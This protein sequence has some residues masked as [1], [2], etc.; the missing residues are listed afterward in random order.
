MST[1]VSDHTAL[2]SGRSWWGGD[3]GAA[4]PLFVTYSF[5]T[6]HYDYL[7]GMS[8]FDT[9]RGSFRELTAMQRQQAQA[10]LTMWD[11]ASGIRFV[12]V[13]AGQGDIRFGS[14]DFSSRFD[15]RD[16]AAFAYYPYA[17]GEGLPDGRGAPGDV[18]L[19]REV[20]GYTAEGT[21]H[22][23]L[24][25]IGHTL[26]LKHPFEGD[27]QLDGT[28][29]NTI[30]TVMSYNGDTPRLGTLDIT[31]IQ[32]IYGTNDRDG[33]PGA[34][35]SWDAATFTLTQAG[36]EAGETLRGV[37]TANVV[38]AGGGDDIVVTWSGRDTIDGGAGD[39][40]IEAG[41][42]DDTL[43]G[44][45]GA[46][47]L[48]GSVGN[49]TLDGGDGDDT[50]LGGDDGND[51]ADGG[52]GNDAIFGGVGN[53]RLSGSAGRDVLWGGV[54]DDRLDGGADADRLHGEYGADRLD[55][56][57]GRDRLEGG[58]GNDTLNG[59]D[60]ADTLIGGG[61]NDAAAGG[62]GDDYLGGGWGIDRFDGGTGNDRL[63]GDDG[64]DR[65][66]G[67]DGKDTL[68]GGTGNDGLTGGLGDDRLLGG[69][70]TD[71]L[72]G[73]AGKD[74]LDGGDGRD[75]LIGGDGDDILVGG[76]DDDRLE[77]AVG[78]DLL[79]GGAGNDRLDGGKG[80]ELSGDTVDYGAARKA[81]LVD[82]NGVA[83]ERPGAVY[84]V[85]HAIGAEI[86]RD[87]I[88]SVENVAGGAGA[89]TLIGNGVAN[90]LSGGSGNDR[91]DGRAGAD[92]LSGGA[93]R[94]R[95][96]FSTRLGA[97]NVDRIADFTSGTDAIDLDAGVFTGLKAGRLA[98]GQFHA[99]T[100]ARDA[101]DRLIFDAG[102][103][104][105]FY[106]ADGTGAQAQV[107]VAL[108]DKVTSLRASDF[109][110]LKGGDGADRPDIGTDPGTGGSGGGTPEDGA[111]NDRLIG[112][113]GNDRLFGGAG[114]D[115]LFGNA[116]DDHLDGGDGQDMLIGGAGSDILDGGAGNDRIDGAAGDD[117][118]IGGAGDDRLDGGSEFSGD[119]VDYETA[120][121]AILVD[122]N[123]IADER[124]NVVYKVY[125]ALGDDIGRDRI[126]NVENVFSGAGNDTLIGNGVANYLSG[127]SGSDRLDGRA[128][129]D[130]LSG[131]VGNDALDG[132]ADFDMLFGGSGN[133]RLDGGAGADLLLG[134]S[135]SDRFVFSTRLGADN[136]DRIS[137]LTSGTDA[138]WLKADIVAG[139]KAGRLAEGQFH[140]G[141]GAQDA[142][143]RV[144]FDAKSRSLYF[145]AD[146]TGAQAQVKIAVFD[147]VVTLA[148]SDFLIV[149]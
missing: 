87:R 120:R 3:T 61:G 137:D 123:G 70:G 51:R 18:Y 41:S 60:D 15:V 59:G 138:I 34:N 96:V 100:G 133:D 101:D 23:L 76:R 69:V 144:I 53:D 108:L 102:T 42:G 67:G 141:T 79:V 35:W 149:V 97:D 84:K 20:D 52:A 40:R 49:D 95:F 83:D 68:E 29:D 127:R 129:E 33:G 135:G 56:G 36:T 146:G 93:G 30:Y 77:G 32:S 12:E 117:I 6:T 109:L 91:L 8:W 143:D 27:L 13:A 128:G 75:V 45:A 139:L 38:A 89:D 24:H 16:S 119:R 14:Y 85:Y 62:A 80:G 47:T 130:T 72:F 43:R 25:E 125:H 136:V 1:T 19:G 148:A 114:L 37:S 81:I 92:I 86:G 50:L 103:K 57:A 106:D 145:D 115:H 105:L 21:L 78:D 73:N 140:A 10:A 82:L 48:D 26:G 58:E 7:D 63:V 134:G 22:V 31:A 9:F 122:L 66:D 118:L 39:D 94:D 107:K 54:G 90:R 65:L 111:G 55:G 126:G 112:G 104:T 17:V 110:I 5:E 113:S 99:G 121:E 74:R 44:G 131:G 11:Q 2:L 28:L 116:G 4:G 71:Q 132:G 142:D 98:E 64:D 88:G 147:N 124:P 46:D